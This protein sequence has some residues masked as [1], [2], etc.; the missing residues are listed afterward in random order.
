M[1]VALQV[2]VVTGGSRGLGLGIVEDLLR[3]GYR[4]ATCS[5]SKTDALTHLKAV[6]GPQRR[7]LWLP[8]EIGDPGQEES[9]FKQVMEWASPDPLYALVN[10]AGVAED[11]VLATFPNTVTE[12]IIQV[13]LLGTLRLCRLALKAMLVQGTGGRI[14]NLSSVASLRGHTGLAVYAASKAGIDGLTRSLA[15]EV[16]KRN[17]TVNS[18]APG[19]LETDMSSSL[20]ED[21]RQKVINRTPLRRLGSVEDVVP[22]VRF[23]LSED[24][25]FITGQTIIVDGGMTC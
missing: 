24:A 21:Q 22:V 5:R 4:V 9:F 17:I 11:G 16:G 3:H 12:R 13:N 7:M 23:L 15:R 18:V 20:S 14:V 10:N 2:A 1:S 8:C 19:Y 25:R 6:Y